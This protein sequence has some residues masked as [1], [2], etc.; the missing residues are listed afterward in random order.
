LQNFKSVSTRKINQ[1][2]GTPGVPVWQRN[3]YDHII[4]DQAALQRITAYIQHNPQRWQQ[5][6]LHPSRLLPKPNLCAPSQPEIYNLQSSK[7]RPI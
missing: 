5:D 2:R 3:Y 6:Q 1:Q 4:R 7:V